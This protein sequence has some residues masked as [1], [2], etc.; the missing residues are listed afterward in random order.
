[1]SLLIKI[2][3]TFNHHDESYTYWIIIYSKYSHAYNALTACLAHG[4]QSINSKQLLGGFYYCGYVIGHVN[5]LPGGLT[6]TSHKFRGALWG[7]NAR[8]TPAAQWGEPCPLRSSRGKAG[9]RSE[10]HPWL[11]DTAA[12]SGPAVFGRRKTV[13]SISCVCK[14]GKNINHRT[15]VMHFV[16][17]QLSYWWCKIVSEKYVLGETTE[18][19]PL[20][21]L[22]KKNIVKTSSKVYDVK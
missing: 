9:H 16:G 11:A 14:G 10:G 18:I 22:R 1:M 12:V 17:G 5:L 20:T 19:F 15:S 7:G 6:S 13:P 8:S 2:S 21:R 4:K 3:K